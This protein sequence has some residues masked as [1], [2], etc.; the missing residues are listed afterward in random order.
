MKF[1][2]FEM[3]ETKERVLVKEMTNRVVKVYTL[4][5]GIPVGYEMSWSDLYRLKRE[6]ILKYVSSFR[7]IGEV[8]APIFFEIDYK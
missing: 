2:V 7:T 3:T 8:P 6:N 1:W 5:R 4:L